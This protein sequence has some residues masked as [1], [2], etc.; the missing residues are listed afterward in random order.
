MLRPPHPGIF[1]R[2]EIIESNKLSVTDAAKILGVTRPALSKLLNGRASLSP[3]MALRFEK[4]FGLRMDT[5]LR[6]QTSYDI[7]QVR[8]TA[9]KVKVRRYKAA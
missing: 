1:L 8:K 5:L 6:M 2:E 4:A 9:N 3:E 7:A